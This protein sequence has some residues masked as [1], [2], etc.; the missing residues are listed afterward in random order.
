MKV[1]RSVCIITRD[2][3]A[4]RDFHQDVLEITAAGDDD[5]VTFCT[6]GAKF[7]L[8]AR[9]NLE[10]WTPDL[11]GDAGTSNCFLEFE[12]PD[13]DAEY[14]RLLALNVDIAKPPTTQPWGVRSVW[15]RDPDG[16]L[17]NFYARGP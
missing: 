4:L 7:S 5:F 9:E 15:F 3:A 14:E 13:V 1:L 10:R 16:N 6:D 8:F 11:M 2:V 17:V 12:V